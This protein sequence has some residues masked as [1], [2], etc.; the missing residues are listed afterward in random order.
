MEKAPPIELNP[1]R[2]RRR[3]KRPWG[4]RLRAG[5][6]LLFILGV[7]PNPA[8]RLTW[9]AEQPFPDSG[10]VRHVADGDTV[11][12][13][14]SDEV[15]R[16]VRL[17]GIDAPEMDDPREE[18]AFSAFLSQRFVSHHLWLREVRLSY[19]FSPQDE[20]GRVL[21]YLWVG[22]GDLFNELVIREGYAAAFL[23][24]PFRKDYQE[25]FRT[26][27][28]EARKEDKGLWRR[29]PPAIISP[30]EV[31]GHLGRI[32]SVRFRCLEVVEKKSFL[33][34]RPADGSFEAVIARRRLPLFPEAAT[35]T[36]KDVIVTGF[37]EEFK[38]RPQIMLAF[39]RQLRLT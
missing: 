5:S 22:E 14:F 6:A 9:A 37:L 33:Y 28:A 38:G 1:S 2:K 17:I 26:A 11:T 12:I 20:Y 19:D 15:E 13:R 35:L 8:P 30:L 27:Q 18:A 21:A 32:I 34:L 23:K 3:F 16:R 10:T 7:C 24:Y 4:R 36:G 39:A 29:D 25:R 31:R